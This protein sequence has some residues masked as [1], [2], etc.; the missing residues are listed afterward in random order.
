MHRPCV[1]GG[2]PDRRDHA[3]DRDARGA[4]RSVDL[5]RLLE[6]RQALPVGQHRDGRA[7]GDAARRQADRGRDE[8]R[9]V[10]RARRGTRLR[11]D[12]PARLGRAHLLQGHG[13]RGLHLE[14]RQER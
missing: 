10:P 5:H 11:P 3:L 13:A 12:V 7:G 2:L 6:L 14:V 8:V 1:H 9:P 4:D